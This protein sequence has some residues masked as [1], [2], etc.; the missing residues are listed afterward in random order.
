MV[1][2]TIMAHQQSVHPDEWGWADPHLKQRL[3]RDPVA[4]LKEYGLNVPAGLRADIV[5]DLVRIVSLLW[6]DG[7]IVPRGQFSIDPW[8]EGLLFGRGV[9]ESTR[10]IDSIP[11]L[12]TWHID[13]LRSTAALLDIEV[14]PGRLPDSTQ[15]SQYVRSLAATDVVVR[16]NVTAGRPGQTGLV[17]MSAAVQPHPTS[18]VRL[19]SRRSP[20]L[21]GQPYLAWKT[22]QYA[23]RLRTGQQAFRAGFDTALMIDA[24]DNILEA[25]HA[26]IFVRLRDGWATPSAEGGGLLPGTVRRHLLERAPIPIRERTVPRA[27]LGEVQE[28]FLTNSNV[29]IVP[30]TQIDEHAIPIGGET[31]E[32]MRWLE[33]T[34]AGADGPR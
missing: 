23:S 19:Q 34:T 7:R 15:V 4:V 5:H 13:R 9:W 11:W 17:W 2:G 24:D 14:A 12:W 28:A 30:V 16:L 22:F 27:L 31:Q 25:A 1:K 20:D 18:S 29:G 8:D 6:V 26:N 32:L 10:T 21:K 3:Q 33:G